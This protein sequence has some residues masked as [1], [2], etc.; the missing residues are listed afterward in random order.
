MADGYQL[1]QQSLFRLHN[2]HDWALTYYNRIWFVDRQSFASH[3][4][5]RRFTAIDNVHPFICRL[6]PKVPAMLKQ[7]TRTLIAIGVASEFCLASHFLLFAVAETPND[8]LPP[9]KAAANQPQIASPAATAP[10]D[11]APTTGVQQSYVGTNKCFICHRP[12]TNTWSETKHAHAFTDL[13]EKYRNDAT[14]HKCHLTAFGAREGYAAGTDKDLLMVGCEAC[15]GPGARHVDAAQRF[16]LADPGEEA[17]IEKEMR[18]SI[19]KNPPSNICIACHQVQR[20]RTHPAYDGQLIQSNKTTPVTACGCESPM[21]GRSTSTPVVTASF[22]RY[23]TKTCGGCH[24]DQYKQWSVEKHSALARMLPAKYANDQSCQTCHPSANAITL[25]PSASSDAHHNWVGV[26]CE[27]CHG[28]ALEHVRF[29]K[30][31]ISGP[32]LGSKLE[33]AARD[34][35]RKG[36]PENS[37]V[38]CHVRSAHK[39]HVSFAGK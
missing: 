13:P 6:N 2:A 37:C 39:E 19:V 33:Q 21:L 4:L 20:H 17:K 27:T 15:H 25:N 34:A 23:S 36:K 10:P 18:D 24:Y 30:Q 12:Q 3:H 38:Q 28:P 29:N 31:F 8:T 11:K 5:R 16:A 9:A 7:I 32:P 35:I 26:A 22:S 1:T 14:C